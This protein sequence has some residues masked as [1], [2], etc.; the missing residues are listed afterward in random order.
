M[1]KKGPFFSERSLPGLS[2]R[3]AAMLQ[4]LYLPRRERE[5]REKT[6]S[7]SVARSATDCLHCDLKRRD[8]Q[9]LP[10]RSVP[11][12]LGPQSVFLS[13]ALSLLGTRN[14]S[15]KISWYVCLKGQ[16]GIKVKDKLDRDLPFPLRER[17][18]F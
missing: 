9:L 4:K 12:T 13:P 15:V 1:T 7:L 2:P 6:E 14:R 17:I 5:M 11:P 10:S 8:V 18:V 16:E 3:A